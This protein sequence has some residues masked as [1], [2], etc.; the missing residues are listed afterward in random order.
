MNSYIKGKPL[1]PDTAFI[2]Q[3]F[4]DGGMSGKDV[5][6][7]DYMNPSG[8][9]KYKK[10][11]DFM[12]DKKQAVSS[13]SNS[14]ENEYNTR[15]TALLKK[16]NNNDSNLV[17][18]ILRRKKKLL[19]EFNSI[20]LKIKDLQKKKE[21]LE[22]KH[23][24]LEKEDKNLQNQIH[25]LHDEEKQIASTLQKEEVLLENDLD[26]IKEEAGI[27]KV[28]MKNLSGQPDNEVEAGKNLQL[29]EISSLLEK[30]T[31]FHDKVRARLE[32]S[33]SDLISEDF[34]E[35]A[36]DLYKYI[37][38][39]RKWVENKLGELE[40]NSFGLD[41]QDNFSQGS[42]LAEK[43]EMTNSDGEE[44]ARNREEDLV[45]N[46]EISKGKID[47]KESS[48]EQGLSSSQEED[49]SQKNEDIDFNDSRD[50]I[51][52]NQDTEEVSGEAGSVKNSEN[53]GPEDGAENS[54]SSDDSEKGSNLE[55]TE[56]E[57]DNSKHDS[58]ED[59]TH[60]VSTQDSE[61]KINTSEDDENI[62]MTQEEKIFL[63]QKR[64]EKI[65]NFESEADFYI[66]QK[67]LEKAEKM[68][69]FAK[70]YYKKLYDEGLQMQEIKKHIDALD[71][72]ID[73]LKEEKS[74]E[75][76]EAK[77][78]SNKEIVDEIYSIISDIMS[79]LAVDDHE[80][81]IKLMGRAKDL[82]NKIDGHVVDKHR[83]YEEVSELK[84][85]INI[86]RS[87]G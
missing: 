30:E 26:L 42:G 28:L 58:A 78:E 36:K 29:D 64:V 19:E 46:G 4:K 48:F 77:M 14:V 67:D 41:S 69:S 43:A 8:D 24:A 76:K 86:K 40:K 83:I 73:K 53:S 18:Y 50:D 72:R 15:P 25:Q 34:P 71:S 84:K 38:E 23:F 60:K 80:R 37:K 3:N 54:E 65:E 16:I 13:T 75:E 2:I 51:K 85:L 10:E 55:N 17:N 74:A 45:V 44:K 33:Y 21:I 1:K 59:S 39:H 61:S 9:E 20:D 47:E 56:N 63:N 62:S 31:E 70:Y 81:A 52:K 22:K 68:L 82:Y 79:S 6:V 49:N 5:S 12:S 35:D 32:S 57:E 11:N 66:K 27:S 87:N 7:S